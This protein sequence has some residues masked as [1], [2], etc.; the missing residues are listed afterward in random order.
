MKKTLLFFL[1]TTFITSGQDKWSTKKAVISFE[2]SVP[3]FVP[4]QAKNSSVHCELNSKKSSIFFVMY[5]KDFHFER[6]LMQRHFNE[7][8]LESDK[9]PKAIFKGIIE[10]FE[11]TKDSN[12]P[13]T[14]MIT[15]TI[16]VH[17]QSKKMR[18]PA[19]FTKTGKKLELST[20]FHLTTDE[21]QIQIPLLVQDKISKNVSVDLNAILE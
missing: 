8:Y 17:G 2:A 16:T 20:S 9:Y 14:Y 1:L 12:F 7:S 3:Y 15:G 6:S 4:I 11:L 18:V 10:K 21:F 19:A 13:V 5:I